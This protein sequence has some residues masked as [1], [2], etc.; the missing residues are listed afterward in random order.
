MID[1]VIARQFQ[2]QEMTVDD[3]RHLHERERNLG[4]HLVPYEIHEIYKV[5]NH[6]NVPEDTWE[7]LRREV[8]IVH[9]RVRADALAALQRGEDMD[10]L[11]IHHWTDI[12]VR[13][14]GISFKT[15][16]AGPDENW[17]T[18]KSKMGGT[19]RHL[20]LHDPRTEAAT[21]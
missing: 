18:I 20:Q 13:R 9:A 7:R 11:T 4:C 10:E 16:Q 14:E 2:I 17:R 15:T 3:V 8:G 1:H 12:A 5:P 21:Q 19:K 6:G